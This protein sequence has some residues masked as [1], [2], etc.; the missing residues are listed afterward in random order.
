MNKNDHI[1]NEKLI[2]QQIYMD[3][4]EIGDTIPSVRELQSRLYLSRNSVL[5]A[6][7]A[8]SNK[9]FLKKGDSP[10]Q[11]YRLC[12]MPIGITSNDISGRELSVHYLLPFTT[13]NYTINKYLSSFESMFTRHGINLIFNNTHNSVAEEGR[14]LDTIYSKSASLRPD[15]LFLTTCDSISNP[16]L[17]LLQEINK[18]IPCILIDRYFHGRNFHYIGVSNS[19]IGSRTAEYLLQLGHKHIAYIK[20]YSKISTVQDRF[21]SFQNTLNAFS[22]NLEEQNVFTLTHANIGSI[23]EIQEEIDYIGSKILSLSPRPTAVVCSFDRIAVALIN[24][25]LKN[26]IS[27]PNDI[28]IIGC[29]NDIDVG[30]MSPV[31]ISTYRHPYRE[32]AKEAIARMADIKNNRNTASC[33]VE[34][35][36]EF[37]PGESAGPVI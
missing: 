37:C 20:A 22:V 31:P 7:Q 5:S 14:L 26:N 18:E 30:A 27:V 36:S 11:G 21:S 12:E 3:E 16:N 29:D 13:W 24:F 19:F 8:L 23:S 6:L 25:F 10:R 35:F 28:S 1:T 2:L 15:F 33:F 17:E 4:L 34:F 32:C 9:G